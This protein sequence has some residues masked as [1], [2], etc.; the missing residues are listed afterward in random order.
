MVE[1]EGR[2]HSINGDLVNNVTALRCA[3]GRA[4][5]P[6]AS[7]LI[8]VGRANINHGPVHPLLLDA[9][10]RGRLDIVDLLIENGYA[11]VNQTKTNDENRRNSLIVS[12]MYGHTSI[13]EY[14]IKRNAELESKTHVDGNTA[15]R[16]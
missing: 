14:L 8:D 12:V 4:H 2:M 3:L 15:L 16:Q 5:F 1:L 13:V 7:T 6:V 9:V 10:I 11:D